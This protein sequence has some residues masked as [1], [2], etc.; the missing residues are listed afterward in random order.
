MNLLLATCQRA[1]Q[2]AKAK[3]KDN[4]LF[5]DNFDIKK[6]IFHIAFLNNCLSKTDNLTSKEKNKWKD[7]KNKWFFSFIDLGNTVHAKEKLIQIFIREVLV[8]KQR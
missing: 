8:I 5:L 6:T 1:E 7:D 4:S 3:K 2:E